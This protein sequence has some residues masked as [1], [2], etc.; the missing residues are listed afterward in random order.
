[1]RGWG[2]ESAPEARE[3]LWGAPGKALVS[4]STENYQPPFLHFPTDRIWYPVP[5]CS[6]QYIIQV[7]PPLPEIWMHLL[8][9]VA[10][11]SQSHQ[12]RDAYHQLSIPEV[13][14]L[15]LSKAHFPTAIS[16]T[17]HFWITSSS[18]I[19]IL[20]CGPWQCW[21]WKNS[22]HS[23]LREKEGTNRGP[24]CPSSSASLHVPLNTG[25]VSNIF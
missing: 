15:D 14:Q 9:Y 24:L 7:I 20:D 25:P 19:S 12:W 11:F 18:S 1:M 4:S 21:P 10:V 8:S 3:A 22:N 13:H 2:A 6:S 17:P 16:W 23:C 5:R